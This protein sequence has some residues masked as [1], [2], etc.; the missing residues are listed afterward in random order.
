MDNEL[1]RKLSAS[2]ELG[3]IILGQ[4]LKTQEDKKEFIKNI[5]KIQK[6]LSMK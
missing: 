6:R 5:M 4:K 3:N 1:I 2:E